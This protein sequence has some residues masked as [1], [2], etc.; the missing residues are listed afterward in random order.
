M[1]EFVAVQHDL[2]TYYCP[3]CGFRYTKLM[4]N[5]FLIQFHNLSWDVS[6]AGEFGQSIEEAT[7]LL[8]E[9]DKILA[10]LLKPMKLSAASGR[11]STEMIMRE[12]EREDFLG[13]MYSLNRSM[14]V[15]Q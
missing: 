6:V 8:V 7:A 4:I 5:D 14:D 9:P 3:S 1:K 13:L 10:D 11:S 12:F 15:S 2:V